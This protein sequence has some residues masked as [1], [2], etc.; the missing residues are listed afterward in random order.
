MDEVF[1]REPSS[2]SSANLVRSYLG[3]LLLRE[4]GSGSSTNC[5]KAVSGVQ[6]TSLGMLWELFVQ[7]DEPVV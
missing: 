6:T 1:L 5:D 7:Y 3:E 4:A 2:G